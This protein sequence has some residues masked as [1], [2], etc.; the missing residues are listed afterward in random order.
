VTS[1]L[2]MCVHMCVCAYIHVCVQTC[3]YLTPGLRLYVHT[4]VSIC[5]FTSV[6][7]CV[8]ICAYKPD[9]HLPEHGCSC[10][11]W[12]VVEVALPPG[13]RTADRGPTSTSRTLR[14]RHIYNET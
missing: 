3:A 4:C 11:W 10:W 5:V 2:Q 9:R 6:C 12:F 13:Y 7:M 1:C 8:C 14:P